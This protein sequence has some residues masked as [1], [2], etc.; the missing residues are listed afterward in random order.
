MKNVPVEDR[1]RLVSY[2]RFEDLPAD[3]SDPALPTRKIT[4]RRA[5]MAERG[6]KFRRGLARLRLHEASAKNS[7]QGKQ[8][9]AQ[10]G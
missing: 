8:A 5:N 2:N 6:P 7:G 3:P 10:E 1:S 4:P 9:R